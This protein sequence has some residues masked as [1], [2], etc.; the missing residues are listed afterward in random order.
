MTIPF[1]IIINYD[2]MNLYSHYITLPTG[3]TKCISLPPQHYCQALAKELGCHSYWTD[4]GKAAAVG[5]VA[6]GLSALV[7]HSLFTAG[8]NKENKK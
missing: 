4:V 1:L 8:Q 6:I 5:V 3:V 2:L 7:V